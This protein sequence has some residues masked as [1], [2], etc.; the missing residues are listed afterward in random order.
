MGIILVIAVAIFL[1]V[2]DQFVGAEVVSTEFVPV[3]EY[4]KEC[5]SQTTDEAVRLLGLQGGYVYMPDF[6]RFDPLSYVNN[7][8]VTLPYWYHKGESR[9]PTLE[10]MENDISRY[11]KEN[12]EGC[13]LGFEGFEEEFEIEQTGDIEVETHISDEE[14][15]IELVYPLSLKLRGQE[16][17]EEITKIRTTNNIR[18]GKI[19]SLAKDIMDT[20]NEQTFL[21]NN[22]L[23]MI[24]VADLPYEGLEVACGKDWSV[25]GQIKPQV[26]EMVKYNF[27]YLNFKNTKYERSGIDYF[28]SF[29][30]QEVGTSNYKDIRVKTIYDEEY[31]MEIDVY[32]SHGDITE[33]ID[34]G[35]PD[36]IPCL[37]VYHHFY[38]IEY[39][40]VFQLTDEKNP[41]DTYNFFF[42]SPVIIDKNSA[43]RSKPIEVV[44]D[45]FNTITSD[46]YCAT[47]EYELTV[48]AVDK[49]SGQ[50][51][52]DAKVEYQCVNFN[53]KMGVTEQPTFDG[54][55]IANS[56]P[57]AVERFPGCVNGFII[58]TKEGYL[59][60]ELQETADESTHGGSVAVEMTPLRD[61]GY[62]F[63]IKEG[64]STRLPRDNEVIYMV[65]EDKENDYRTA[66]YYPTDLEQFNRLSLPIRDAVYDVDARI[67][68]DETVVG[69]LEILEWEVTQA[70]VE[71]ANFLGLTLLSSDPQPTTTEDYV[72]LYRNVIMTESENYEPRLE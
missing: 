54:I 41:E 14:I 6:I 64:D 1:F 4:V 47:A 30:E 71:R 20:E 68:V 43:R 25:Q 2:K 57:K 45:S 33:G 51:L 65:I 35:M 66:I 72:E 52:A 55:P 9:A 67:I 39:P 70:D 7:A 21:E 19:Y 40:V 44:D 28:E 27:H 60:G 63:V 18:L 15:E 61:L 13:T 31:G 42:A 50:E 37:N 62:S 8:G 3:A 49:L 12:I 36:V 53:C 32:P 48:F 34:L 46:D 59:D 16:Q 56:L 17:V 26:Q 24:A 11:V 38:N 23:D 5:A 29:Y 69:G 22:T 58:T 10:L